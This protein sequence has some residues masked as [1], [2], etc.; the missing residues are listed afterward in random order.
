MKPEVHVPLFFRK[1]TRL[2]IKWIKLARVNNLRQ[3]S[4]GLPKLQQH[5]AKGQVAHANARGQE[6]E[7]VIKPLQCLVDQ[8]IWADRATDG[9]GSQR[10]QRSAEERDVI[11]RVETVPYSRQAVSEYRA[12]LGCPLVNNETQPAIGELVPVVNTVSQTQAEL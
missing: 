9:S 12:E 5:K 4:N 3:D 11:T 2:V 6:S 7:E 10:A 8:K 1:K